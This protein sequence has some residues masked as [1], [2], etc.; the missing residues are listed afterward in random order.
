[1]A[2]DVLLGDHGVQAVGAQEQH[3]VGLRLEREGVD[4]HLLVGAE[5]PCDHAPLWMLL[6]LVLRELAL[7]H[8]LVDERVVLGEALE[9]AVAQE[10][11]AAVAHVR[12]RDG[13]VLAD[14]RRR[15]RRPHA[16]CLGVGARA[17]VDAPVRHADRRPQRLLALMLDQVKLGEG[18]GTHA[19]R[20]LARERATHA[21]GDHEERRAQ[22]ER[23]LVGAANVAGLGQ[24]GRIDDT[25]CHPPARYS[26]CVWPIVTTSPLRSTRR[27]ETRSPF[28]NVPLVELRSSTTS[29]S[30]PWA[31]RA[32]R[33]EAYPSAPSGI[34]RASSRPATRSRPRSISV[35]WGS[36]GL[37]TT[38]SRARR[39]GGVSSA[40]GRL[41]GVST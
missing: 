29:P 35:P 33:P 31:N 24:A 41:A 28:T 15:H 39:R 11:G 21:V 12:E 37:A 2:R 22:E 27:P 26:S 8:E 1:D 40:A 7:A 4:L 38:R 17:L 9:G 5:R 14:E 20:E 13:A 30:W 16:R 6:G 3:V 10:V 32:W 25:S 19:R 18:L 23:V 34:S 36:S